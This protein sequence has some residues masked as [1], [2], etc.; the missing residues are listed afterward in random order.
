MILKPY[1]I[2]FYTQSHSVLHIITWFFKEKTFAIQYWIDIYI[3]ASRKNPSNFFHQSKDNN[4]KLQIQMTVVYCE[5]KCTT[6][7]ILKSDH[8]WNHKGELSVSLAT[9]QC[10]LHNQNF[11]FITS[12]TDCYYYAI[13]VCSDTP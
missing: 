10:Y 9:V 3:S 5:L 11:G 12:G 6:I 1:A 13:I 4:K 8:Q 7:Y 2:Y